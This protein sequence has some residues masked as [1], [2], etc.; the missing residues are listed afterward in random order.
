MPSSRAGWAE[1]C[2]PY[3]TLCSYYIVVVQVCHKSTVCTYYIV[4][5]QVCHIMHAWL[6]LERGSKQK[7]GHCF[8]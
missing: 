6:A 4:M 1:V 2:F 5:V 7:G 3:R 8:V